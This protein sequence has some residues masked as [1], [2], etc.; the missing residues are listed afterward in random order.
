M[1]MIHMEYEVSQTILDA[2]NEL[3]SIYRYWFPAL[4]TVLSPFALHNRMATKIFTAP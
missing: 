4:E 2:A 3:G 1:L